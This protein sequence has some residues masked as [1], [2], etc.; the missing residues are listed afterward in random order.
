LVVALAAVLHGV[1]DRPHTRHLLVLPFNCPGAEAETDS[2]CAGLLDTV[3]AKLSELRRF[4]SELS[5]VPTSE[6]RGKRIQSAEDAHRIFAVDLVVTGTVM[7]SG[8]SLRIPLELIDAARLRQIRS[9]LLTTEV[10]G[11]FVLQDRV[12]AAVE[13]MLDLELEATE[14]KALIAGGTRD[15]EAAELFLEARGRIAREPTAVQL[16]HAMTLYRQA[17][18]IDPEYA[19]AMV[20]LANACEQRY[21]LE[22]DSIWLEHG[23][24]YA[25]RA[26]ALAPDLPSAQLAA[27]RFEF[28]NSAYESAI[29]HL[30]RAISLDPLGVASYLY[31]AQAHEAVGEKEAA[32]KAMARA[33]RTGPDDWLTHYRIGRFF[34]VE[35]GDAERAVAFFEKVIDLVP[36]SSVG[37]SAL[38]SCLFHLGDRAGAREHLER[39]VEIGSDYEAFAN[40]ATLEFYERNY[41]AAAGLYERALELDD[42]DHMVWIGLAEARRFGGSEPESVRDAYEMAVQRVSRRVEIDPD[43]LGLHIDRASILIQLDEHKEARF[44][45]DRLALEGVEAPDMM[46]SLAEI[47]EM[48]GERE[49]ALMWIRRALQAG[50]PLHVIEDYAAFEDLRSDPRFGRSVE[51]SDESPTGVSATDSKQGND[52]VDAR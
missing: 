30:G 1:L 3:T 47:F 16:T 4:R 20:E 8:D 26:V 39:A 32:E 25:R 34:Y 7:R 13:E 18:E 43:N 38:G 28:A 36:Q 50:Y 17:L 31:L 51:A 35:R 42:G 12:V 52:E 48:L 6:V 40:L 2:L 45:L 14:R 10:S 19:D 44:I 22:G 33:V 37:Y 27:G 24:A 41:T 49:E 9:R 29:H 23:A 46:Y 5:V 21:Q 11:E 15:A